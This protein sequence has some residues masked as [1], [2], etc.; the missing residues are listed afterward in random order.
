MFIT[1]IVIGLGVIATVCY[2]LLSE[3]PLTFQ[4]PVG[5]KSG[6]VPLPATGNIDDAVDTLLRELVD[7]ESL[8]EEEGYDVEILI[9]DIE[10]I[11]DFGQSIDESEL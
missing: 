11:S 6:T 2:I 7:E 5:I 3:E 9:S 8:Y 4:P 1:V 10:E